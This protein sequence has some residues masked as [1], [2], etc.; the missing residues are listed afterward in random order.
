MVVDWRFPCY[1]QTY[2]PSVDTYENHHP[3]HRSIRP[4]RIPNIISVDHLVLLIY[5]LKIWDHQLTEV[6]ATWPT[7]KSSRSQL[8]PSKHPWTT[9][10]RS[11]LASPG[12]K[13]SPPIW[14]GPLCGAGCGDVPRWIGSGK[15]HRRN[16]HSQCNF[17]VKNRSFKSCWKTWC[18][19]FC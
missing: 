11:S 16:E 14:E 1:N 2:L 3:C 7:A 4:V 18:T 10:S 19:I 8:T 6:V 15:G 13:I 17:F 9:S 5:I 12:P